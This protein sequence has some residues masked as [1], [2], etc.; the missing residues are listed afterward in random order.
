M[1]YDY[2]DYNIQ[3]QEPKSDHIKP[4]HWVGY[5][6]ISSVYRDVLSPAFQYI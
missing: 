2:S 5:I 1:T 4:K 3:M 6:L